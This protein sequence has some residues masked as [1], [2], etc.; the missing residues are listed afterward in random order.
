MSGTAPRTMRIL[1][2]DDHPMIRLAV[3]QLLANVPDLAVCGEADSVAD[4]VDAVG[5]L[6][7]D[8]VIVDLS[9][10][11]ESGLDLIRQLIALDARLPIVVFSMHDDAALADVAFRAGARAYVTKQE[12]PDAL[13]RAIRE[14]LAGRQYLGDVRT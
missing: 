6:T 2:V 13:V 4:G 3:R 14:A 9:L 12:R 7:P 8:L 5:R 10:K 11:G 1:L